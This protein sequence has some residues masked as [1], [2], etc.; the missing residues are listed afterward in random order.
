MAT[1]RGNETG[2][3]NAVYDEPDLARALAWLRARVRLTQRQVDER[4][5]EQ[6]GARPPAER[7][8]LSEVFYQALETGKRKPRLAK[9]EAILAA[10]GS[11]RAELEGLVASRPWEHEPPT[12]ARIRA[13]TPKPAAYLAAA[14]DALAGGVW[15]S[16]VALAAEP[17]ERGQLAE[18]VEHFHNLRPSDRAAL[19]AEA[20]WRRWRQ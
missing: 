10:L 19:L 7:E 5:R 11:D 16:P 1:G 20:R 3:P 13:H 4:V 8:T 12:R 2:R 17:E 6:Q 14:G 9:L 15:S 18:L